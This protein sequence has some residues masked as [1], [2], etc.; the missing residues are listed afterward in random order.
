MQSLW[1]GGV[2]SALASSEQG[3]KETAIALDPSDPCSLATLDKAWTVSN[4]KG[5]RRVN[6]LKVEIPAKVFLTGFRVG[7]HA[8]VEKLTNEPF[9]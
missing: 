9:G 6:D 8:P 1:C 7:I 2:D 4:D 3:A 5:V